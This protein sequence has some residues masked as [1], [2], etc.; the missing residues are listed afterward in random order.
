MINPGVKG[1]GRDRMEQT[2]LVGIIAFALVHLVGF[3]GKE[4]GDVSAL[5]LGDKLSLRRMEP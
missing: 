1:Q 3:G 4:E 5:G 2:D